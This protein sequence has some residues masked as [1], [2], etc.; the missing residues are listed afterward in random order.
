MSCY[1]LFPFITLFSTSLPFFG[2]FNFASPPF[3]LLPVPFPHCI[4]LQLWSLIKFNL[5]TKLTIVSPFTDLTVKSVSWLTPPFFS[6]C[7]CLYLVLFDVMVTGYHCLSYPPRAILE[8]QALKNELFS[9]KMPT[10]IQ[11][12]HLTQW[13]CGLQQTS[14]RSALLQRSMAP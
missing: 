14:T 2:L 10:Q 3:S 13:K 4:Y 6:F 7:K 9:K 11:K 12:Q 5:I 8:V 1:S